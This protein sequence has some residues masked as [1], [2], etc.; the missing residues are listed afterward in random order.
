MVRIRI[1]FLILICMTFELSAASGDPP[2]EQNEGAAI[3]KIDPGSPDPPRSNLKYYFYQLKNSPIVTVH[4]LKH[5]PPGKTSK[6]FSKGRNFLEEGRFSEAITSLGEAVAID[7]EYTYALID[8]AVAYGKAG[9]IEKAIPLLNSAIQYDPHWGLAY[10][11]L[12][13]AY[14]SVNELSQAEFTARQ[15]T[16]IAD[17]PEARFVLGLSLTMEDRF[18]SETQAALTQAEPLFPQAALLL[19][20]VLAGR[21]EIEAAK[22]KISS[23]LASPA[24]WNREMASEWLALLNRR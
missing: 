10:F 18:T 17:S 14:I 8:L 15:M 23:Y 5:S 24:V 11:N 20:R 12:A 7:P 1:L 21:G 19:G 4:Q 6:A 3:A 2:S 22:L 9:R 16:E 13:I